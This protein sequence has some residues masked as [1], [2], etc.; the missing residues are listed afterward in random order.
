LT[1]QA[2]SRELLHGQ[3]LV[4]AANAML[5]TLG[6]T[7]VSLRL[8]GVPPGDA[9]SVQLGLS[10][11]PVEDV[12]VSPVV[13]LPLPADVRSGALRY[14]LLMSASAV[15]ALAEARGLDSAATLFNSSL[16]IVHGS[17]LLHISGLAVEV[18]GGIV[19]VYRVTAGE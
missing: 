14:E 1:A 7:E 16:G 6:G 2:A 13:I 4:R 17:S 15:D 10:A 11:I 8:P 18:F 3:A 19:T 9:T 5:R 12:P